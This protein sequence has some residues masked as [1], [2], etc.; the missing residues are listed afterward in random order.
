MSL[1]LSVYPFL[2]DFKTLQTI[3]EIIKIWV[4]HVGNQYLDVYLHMLLLSKTNSYSRENLDN[5]YRDLM[6]CTF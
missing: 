3:L 2:N 4:K 1:F 6:E 5:L